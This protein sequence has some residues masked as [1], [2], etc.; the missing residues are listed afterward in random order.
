MVIL[1]TVD[2]KKKSKYPPEKEIKVIQHKIFAIKM[3][4]KGSGMVIYQGQGGQ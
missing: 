1:V 2:R 3:S 4:G